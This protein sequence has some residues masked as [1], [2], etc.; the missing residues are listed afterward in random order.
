MLQIPVRVSV[1]YYAH[2]PAYLVLIVL[3]IMFLLQMELIAGVCCKVLNFIKKEKERK[4]VVSKM[5]IELECS[6]GEQ[7]L[8][9]KCETL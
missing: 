2:F 3:A 6:S 4:G 8:P 7:H 1:G 5:G 9:S